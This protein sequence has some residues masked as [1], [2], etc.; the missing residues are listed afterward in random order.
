MGDELAFTLIPASLVASSSIMAVSSGSLILYLLSSV[1]ANAFLDSSTS[2][3]A[4][5]HLACIEI[6]S[7]FLAG[8]SCFS[9]TIYFADASSTRSGTTRSFILLEAC[10]ATLSHS[11]CFPI[12]TVVRWRMLQQLSVCGCMP[13]CVHC[14]V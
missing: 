2:Y 1:I 8:I 6:L 7:A 3:K 10:C 9:F 5:H 14:I 11:A 13:R 12:S 4:A